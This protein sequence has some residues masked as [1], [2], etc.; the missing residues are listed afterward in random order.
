MTKSLEKSQNLLKLLKS[1][2]GPNDYNSWLTSE[3]NCYIEVNDAVLRCSMKIYDVAFRW[4]SQYV[5][6]KNKEIDQLT[7]ASR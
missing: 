6:N 2:L 3:N 1:T 7:N 4:V 5:G